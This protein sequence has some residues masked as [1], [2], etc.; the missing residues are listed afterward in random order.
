VS[1]AFSKAASITNI[2]AR[3]GAGLGLAIAKALLPLDMVKFGLR[4]KKE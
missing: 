3:H 2:Q 1:C 4:A